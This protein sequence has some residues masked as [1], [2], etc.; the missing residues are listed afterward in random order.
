MKK[1][2]LLLTAAFLLCLPYTT[3]MA[4]VLYKAKEKK[5]SEENRSFFKHEVGFSIGVFPTIGFFNFGGGWA[6]T[7]DPMFKHTDYLERDNGMYENMYCLGSYSFSYNYRFNPEHSI[8]ASLSWVGKHIDTYWIYGGKIP[9]A[10]YT[11]P[12]TVNGS[13]WKHYFTLQVNYRQ[14]YYRKN[15]KISLYW[16]IAA[17]ITLCVID[18]DILPKETHYTLFGPVSNTKY[19][20]A[21]AMQ[22]NVLGME[23]G[24]KN[25]FLT[26]LGIGTQGILK[27][28]YR[29]KF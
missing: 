2:Y 4:Q 14:T 12:D 10:T 29:Y 11:E 22:L 27:I 25:V 20:F 7:G 9:F 24:G 16:G 28:G 1:I 17:G 26:E 3:T 23:L 15:D 6:F 18:K 8:G 21:P 13:G 19:R 5:K